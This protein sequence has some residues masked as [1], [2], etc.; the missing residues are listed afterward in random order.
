MIKNSNIKN[1]KHLFEKLNISK[2]TLSSK[3]KKD[4]LNKG[5]IIIPPTIY[6]KKNIKILNL[7]TKKLIKKE[8][9]KGGWEGKEKYYKKGKLFEKGTNRLGNLINKHKVFQNL[10]TIPEILA[11]SYEVV[12]SDIKIAGVNLRNPLKNNGK[13]RIHMDWKPRKK[14][15]QKYNV[16]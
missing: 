9:K 5:F 10:I 12:K 3:Q 13:Q 11:A 1:T 7:M 15:S 2:N 8:G 6:M 4:L 16:H 14:K